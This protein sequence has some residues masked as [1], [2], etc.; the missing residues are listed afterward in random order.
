MS[1]IETI[2]NNYEFKNIFSKGRYVVEKNISAYFLKNTIN[3]NRIGIAVSKKIGN[4][5]VRNRLK[6]LFREAYRNSITIEKNK[7]FDIVFIWR[8]NRPLEEATYNNM[9]QEIGEILK[10]VGII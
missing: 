8:K 3:K 7:M 10:K 4:S 5:V 1:K 9:L 6:R 2:K